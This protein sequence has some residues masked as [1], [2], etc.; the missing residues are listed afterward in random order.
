[1]P[2]LFGGTEEV[3]IELLQAQL[4]QISVL[5][6]PQSPHIRAKPQVVGAFEDKKIAVSLQQL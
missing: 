1:M 4:K 3:E 6:R 5:Q 2:L